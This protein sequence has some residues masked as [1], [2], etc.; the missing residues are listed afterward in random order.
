M[1]THA[2]VNLWT[3]RDHLAADR[4]GTLRRLAGLGY[5]AV[6]PFEATDDPAGLRRVADDLGLTVCSAHSHR[7]LGPDPDAVFESVAVL[8]TGLVIVPYGL[9]E[10]AFAGRDAL[11]RTAATLNS[12][13]EGAARYGLALGYHN[14]WWEF[15]SEIDGRHAAEVLA[16]LL[17]PEVF[18]E[19]DTYWAALGGADV[20]GVVTR[21]GD[22]VRALHLKDGPIAKGAAHTA[23]GRGD[24]PTARILAAAPAGALRIVELQT[25]DGDVFEALADSRA[26]LDSP[27]DPS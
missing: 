9:M 10:D 16:D 3:V 22:R 18:L 27:A 24:M 7:L 19:I 21:L 1:T 15:E 25:C 11:R 13:A 14:Y 26:F 5:D 6:E 4:D 12:L 2:A 20:P 8:G 17:A 23:L